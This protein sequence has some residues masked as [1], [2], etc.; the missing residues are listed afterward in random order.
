MNRNEKEIK[1]SSQKKR[2]KRKRKKTIRVAEIINKG[3]SFLG[4]GLCCSP[5]VVL[6]TDESL[7]DEAYYMAKIMFNNSSLPQNKTHK[8]ERP[9]SG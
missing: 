3:C 7:A 9:Q 2:R 6:M 4:R 1:G 5:S 8:A